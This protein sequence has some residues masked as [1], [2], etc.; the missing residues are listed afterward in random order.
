MSEPRAASMERLNPGDGSVPEELAA[1]GSGAAPGGAAAVSS[2]ETASSSAGAAPSMSGKQGSEAGEGGGAQSIPGDGSMPEAVA[3]AGSGADPGGA[4]D[5]SSIE[6]ASRAALRASSSS[7]TKTRA[8]PS[9]TSKAPSTTSR[10]TSSASRRTVCHPREGASPRGCLEAGRQALIARAREGQ[11][12]GTLRS[13]EG[14][15]SMIQ[16]IDERRN[17]VAMK[18]CGLYRG[19]S[20][21]GKCLPL[22][23]CRRPVHGTLRYRGTSLIIKCIPLQYHPT[24]G[25]TPQAPRRS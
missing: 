12:A 3:A 22:G 21:I 23:P 20:L 4:A 10:R 24:I 7:P 6:Q 16:I 14:R 1:A 15:G 19:T 9:T 11:G 8:A 25:P 2:I 13:S 18:K 17:Y 5:V